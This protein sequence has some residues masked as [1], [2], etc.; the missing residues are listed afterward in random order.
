MELKIKLVPIFLPESKTIDYKQ[1]SVECSYNWNFP[2]CIL[3]IDGKYVRIQSLSNAGSLI[4]M[5][6]DFFQ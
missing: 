1:K 4:H 2:N 5:I 3:G 6:K